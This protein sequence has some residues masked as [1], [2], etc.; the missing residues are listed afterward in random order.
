[1]VV[2]K[3]AVVVVGLLGQLVVDRMAVDKLVVVVPTGEQSE[4]PDHR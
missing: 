4:R 2:G 1:M 3:L